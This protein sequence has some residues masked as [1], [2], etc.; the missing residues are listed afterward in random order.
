M[1]LDEL[2]QALEELRDE[3][4]SGAGQVLVATQPSYPLCNTIRMV[5]S[6]ASWAGSRSNTVWI[7]TDQ[8][9]EKPYAPR[10]AWMG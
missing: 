3:L 4:G 10:D 7:A 9:E 1:T 6:E 8:N 5:R 2:I